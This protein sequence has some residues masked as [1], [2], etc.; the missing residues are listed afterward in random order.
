[1]AAFPLTTRIR[2]AYALV[3]QGPAGLL[4]SEGRLGDNFFARLFPMRGEPPVRTTRELLY[5]YTTMPW[6]R[7]VTHRIAM[8]VATVRWHLYAPRTRGGKFVRN[9]DLQAAP[10]PSRW[11]MLKAGLD[12]GRVVE[13]EEH[14]LLTLLREG[15]PQLTGINTRHLRQVHLDLVGES[16]SVLQ[17]NP[18]GMPTAEWPIP[19]S[20]VLALPTSSDPFYQVHTPGWSGQIPVSEM[21]HFVDPNPEN[22]YGRG[23]GIAQS[24]LDELE[25]AEY[26]SKHTRNFFFNSAIPPVVVSA[27]GLEKGETARLEADWMRKNQGF[28]A[29]WK[30]YFMNRKVDIQLLSQTF[31]NMQLGELRKEERDVII[32]TYG[33]PPE[34]LGVL[35]NCLDSSTQVLTRRGW[36]MQEDLTMQDEIGTF[37]PE[38]ERLEYHRPIRII[39]QDYAGPMHYWKTRSVDLAVTPEHKL[40]VKTQTYQPWHLQTSAYSTTVKQQMC[41]R[42]TGGG[43]EGTQK[44]VTVPLVPYHPQSNRSDGDETQGRVYDVELFARFL[45]YWVSEGS[46]GNARDDAHDY[47]IVVHQNEGEIADDMRSVFEYMLPGG[48][49]E[50][51]DAREFRSAPLVKLRIAHKSLWHWLKNNV[52]A[53]QWERRLPVEVFEWPSVAQ[54]F[55]LDALMQGDGSKKQKRTK[56]TALYADRYYATT[57]EGLA[58]DIQR[59]C[60]QLGLRSKKS[61]REPGGERRPCYVVQIS[62]KQVVYVNTSR[63]GKSVE[64]PPPF[65]IEHYEGIVWCVE[66]PNHLFVTRR[67]SII[68]IH[69]NSNRATISASET[70]FAKYTVLP[71]LEYQREVLQARLVPEF[72]ERL[73]LD[74][75]TPLPEDRDFTLQAMKAAPEA[76]LVDQWQEVAGFAPLPGELGNTFYRPVTSQ[77][78][79]TDVPPPPEVIVPDAGGTPSDTR[80]LRLHQAATEPQAKALEDYA[81]LHA[82]ADQ[83]TPDVRAAF[84]TLIQAL[85]DDTA[86]A[87]LERALAASDAVAAEAA[88]PWTLFETASAP[89]T[90]LLRSALGTAGQIEAT[91]LGTDLGVTISWNLANADAVAYAEAQAADLITNISASSRQAIRALIEEGLQEGT[92][93]KVLAQEI[94]A[95]LGLTEAQLRSLDKLRSQLEA[96]GIDERTIAERLAAMRDKLLTQRATVIARHEL[97]TALNH[98]NLAAWKQGVAQGHLDRAQWR[99]VWLVTED[100]RLCPTI[101]EGVDTADA[102][103]DV[104][105]DSRFILG[106]GREVETAPGHVMCRCIVSLRRKPKAFKAGPPAP[107]AKRIERDARGLIS[108]IVEED[109]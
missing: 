69:S 49:T 10:L 82:L 8:S 32:H 58:D 45:G 25:T 90:D 2:M 89:M 36:L 88:I 3:R 97:L 33:I 11:T 71:R 79:A 85:K 94:K 38:A 42:A 5:A 21:L 104:R 106:D 91:A 95:N 70:H 53:R 14:G 55:L 37:D 101:C 44:T 86:L 46:L 59:L 105:I 15:N 24:L 12:Q 1:M 75:E 57:S 52:G 98:G 84:V 74:Y 93:A 22:P 51:R 99:K 20:W 31:R 80:S 100:E 30:P 26:A 50:E 7:A 109:A 107:R 43:Y 62:S 81:H 96:Q 72:D 56:S 63:N 4:P 18:L 16:F 77:V 6:L 54:H 78:I 61:G 103:S 29:A 41:W 68:S 35:T 87:P 48:C 17:R 23:R 19:P 92:S 34:V 76:F 102:N 67:N 28:F 60:V 27:D 73:I 39:R 65:T 13:I 40:W 9:A 66:V 64:L 83:L 108:R 47:S